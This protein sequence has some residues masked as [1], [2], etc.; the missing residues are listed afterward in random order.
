MS[1]HRSILVAVAT[2]FSIGMTSVAFAGCCDWGTPAPVAYMQGGCG[3][4][5]GAYASIIYATP[6][7]P[8][9][10]Y[11]GGGCGGCGA[12]V[13]SC[14][15][16][17]AAAWGGGYGAGYGGGYG[18]NGLG[19]GGCGGCGTQAVYTTPAPL[20][21]VNQGPDYSGPGVMEPYRTYAPPVEYAPPPGY[22]PY[23][24][25]A[26]YEPSPAYSPYGYPHRYYPRVGYGM[27]YRQHM[28][29]HPHLYAPRAYGPRPYA[30]R[31][32]WRG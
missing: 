29:Y 8:A 27:G 32:Y 3:G 12:P 31:P 11:V 21:V 28:Y 22:P 5:G 9:P 20:Y 25:Q 14:C 26:G 23:A 4:C 6:V 10:I 17:S 2:L 18:Y 19:G 13:T 16:T 7:V 24:L 30:P 15:G 1:L